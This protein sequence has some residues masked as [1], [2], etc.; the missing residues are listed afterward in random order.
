[1]D[2]DT[3]SDPPPPPEPPEP[4]EPPALPPNEAPTLDPIAPFPG[5][6]DTA[7]TITFGD[8]AATANDS[9][10]MVVSF[11]I[12]SVSSGTLTLNGVPVVPGSTLIS[13]GEEVV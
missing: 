7:Q 11:R 9:D 13:A 5:T 8:L 1:M 6:E 2:S 12:E 4:P 10:G 3:D